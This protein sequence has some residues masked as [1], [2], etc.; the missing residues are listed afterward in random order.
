MPSTFSV[1]CIF[2]PWQ[3]TTKDFLWGS[4]IAVIFEVDNQPPSGEITVRLVEF[5]SCRPPT[6]HLIS[7]GGLDGAVVH[8]RGTGSPTR[9]SVGPL[10]DTCEG[11]TEKIFC[12][13]LFMHKQVKFFQ[14]FQKHLYNEFIT[15]NIEYCDNIDI[16]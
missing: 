15:T 11:A 2:S 7:A 4:T 8:W 9:A 3:R 16:S 14:C 13:K 12:Y 5:R 1:S 10:I 6:V